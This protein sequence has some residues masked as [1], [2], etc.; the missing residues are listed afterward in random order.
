MLTES[1]KHNNFINVIKF[2]YNE[3]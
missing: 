3:P 1:L 2:H